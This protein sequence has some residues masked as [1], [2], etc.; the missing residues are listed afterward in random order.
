MAFVF[1]SELPAKVVTAVERLSSV[2]CIEPPIGEDEILRIMWLL[3]LATYRFV[4]SVV[5]AL[6]LLKLA[7]VPVP[8]ADPEDPVPATVVTTPVEITILRIR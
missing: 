7:E 4:P 6:G 1:P 5:I 8:F 2:P 3:V